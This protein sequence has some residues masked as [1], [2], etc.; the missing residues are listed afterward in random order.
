MYI[1]TWDTKR[2]LW[3]ESLIQL[4]PHKKDILKSS[5]PEWPSHNKCLASKQTQIISLPVFPA[6][7]PKSVFLSVSG[8]CCYLLAN[9]ESKVW[10]WNAHRL[11]STV[12]N[13][14]QIQ[15]GG[16]GAEQRQIIIEGCK[17]LSPTNCHKYT[18][19]ILDFSMKKIF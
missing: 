15:F 17:D 4:L 8:V 12:R 18:L 14:S 19:L 2:S 16:W 6:M 9:L 1:C 10:L 5:L 11:N 7:S 3:W 13:G